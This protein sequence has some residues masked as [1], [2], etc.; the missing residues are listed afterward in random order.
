MQHAAIVPIALQNACAVMKRLTK[1][2]V[3]IGIANPLNDVNSVATISVMVVMRW[4]N[5]NHVGEF[6]VQNAHVRGPNVTQNG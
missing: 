5:V 6:T 1:A 3:L 2:G 4:P